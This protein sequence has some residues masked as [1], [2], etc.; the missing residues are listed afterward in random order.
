MKKV[1]FLTTLLLLCFT[2]TTYAQTSKEVTG[3]FPQL[4]SLDLTVSNGKKVSKSIQLPLPK[5]V[6]VY[7]YMKI[8]M[9]NSMLFF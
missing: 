6:E 9:V 8:T 7:K 4:V 5:M 1:L 2:A 3:F